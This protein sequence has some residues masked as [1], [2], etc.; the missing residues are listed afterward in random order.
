M[1]V[2]FKHIGHFIELAY[3][4]VYTDI[5]ECAE[6]TDMC[7]QNCHN[8]IGSYNCSC[9]IGYRL[10]MDG[11]GCDDIDECAEMTDRCDQNCHNSVGTYTCSC[12]TG[13]RLNPDGFRC[14]GKYKTN[15]SHRLTSQFNVWKIS[16]QILMSV[17]KGQ[18]CV[19]RT[20]TIPLA[21]ITVV[22]ILGTV[23]TWMGS[24]VM[25]LMNVLK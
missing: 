7:G 9:N 11:F 22:A 16:F 23:S 6:G 18:I 13:Y 10:N 24:D 4:N 15:S 19:V 17:Q 14:D 8:T 3:S 25:I 2:R 20:V 1:L 12:N 21:R 5:D